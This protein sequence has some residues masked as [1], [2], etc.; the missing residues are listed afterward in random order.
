M[1][2][3][4]WVC[5]ATMATMASGRAFGQAPAREAAGREGIPEEMGVMAKELDLT[6]DQIARMKENRQAALSARQDWEEQNKEKV[7]KLRADAETAQQAKDQE[8]LQKLR[9][10]G[11]LLQEA[12][13]KSEAAFNRQ[14]LDILTPEQKAAWAGLKAYRE[15]APMA[16]AAGLSTNQ[17]KRLKETVKAHAVAVAK[18]EDENGEKI[19]KLEQQGRE[20]RAAADAL[21]AEKTR[22]QAENAAAVA[23]ILTP[24]QRTAWV[25][26]K[27]QQE[28]CGR[29]GRL[30]A[31]DDQIAKV[32][33]LSETIAKELNLTPLADPR[34]FNQ[35]REK[36]FKA[37]AEQI[38]TD[39]QRAQ[40]SG[41]P[42]APVAKTPDA[43]R[44]PD[45][46]K[47]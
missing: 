30:N 23:A 31:T 29:L 41:R 25:A 35:A 4:L 17:E 22:L 8:A 24:E 2:W 43:P 18:W 5:A 15:Y 46:A 3:K 7:A 13:A 11:Q 9:E 47:P 21:Q 26:Q 10:Q 38:L 42:A 33:A 1:N 45:A 19:R 12:R 32:K 28:A 20:I 44:Q 6:D 39:E 27:L 16:K 36:L 14:M 37:I 40:L 34:V